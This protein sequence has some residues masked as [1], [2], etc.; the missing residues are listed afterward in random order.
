MQFEL[1][2]TCVSA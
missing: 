2:E 1:K